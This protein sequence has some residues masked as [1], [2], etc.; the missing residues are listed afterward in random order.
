LEDRKREVE[1]QTKE[2]EVK[3]KLGQPD[4]GK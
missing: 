3:L 2:L 1:E 4:F